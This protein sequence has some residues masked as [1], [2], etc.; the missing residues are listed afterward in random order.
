MAYINEYISKQ[1][2]EKYN[3][4]DLM[5]TPAAGPL[6]SR[7]WTIDR[8]T[9]SWLY[10]YAIGI[11]RDEGYK[12]FDY[13]YFFWQEHLMHLTTE[14]LESKGGGKG[15]HYQAR[16]KLIEINLP[17]TLISQK[18]KILSDLQA[19]LSVYGPGGMTGRSLSSNVELIA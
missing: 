13:W 16:L 2:F 14:V 15:Q 1:D 19:A 7:G 10:R 17:P 12:P 9:C 3:I 11:D 18:N 8:E 6:S 5:D 4:Q